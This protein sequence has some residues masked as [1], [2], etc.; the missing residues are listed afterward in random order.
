MRGGTGRLEI[1]VIKCCDVV[2][3]FPELG[4]VFPRFGVGVHPMQD[5][6]HE[7]V[8]KEHRNLAGAVAHDAR[9]LRRHAGTDML[10]IPLGVD[11]VGYDVDFSS[12]SGNTLEIFSDLIGDSDQSRRCA[13]GSLGRALGAGA[14]Y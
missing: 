8:G 14:I 4:A 3:N 13:E 5:T 1:V 2:E 11:A 9:D 7:P 6:A 10:P 12:R